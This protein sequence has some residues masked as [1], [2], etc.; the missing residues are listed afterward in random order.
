MVRGTN[1][2]QV[3]DTSVATVTVETLLVVHIWLLSSAMLTGD[4]MLCT[5]A[6]GMEG[7]HAVLDW[8][9]LTR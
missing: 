1:V 8:Q 2:M 6:G 5:V 9:D 4:R 7:P 3:R